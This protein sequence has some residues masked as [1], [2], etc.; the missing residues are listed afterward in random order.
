M[1]GHRYVSTGGYITAAIMVLTACSSPAA[2]A[3]HDPTDT[4]PPDVTTTAPAPAW[5]PSTT[6]GPAATPDLSEFSPA[7]RGVIEEDTGET[8]GPRAVPTWDQPS[9]TAAA[10]AATTAMTA[11]ARPSL[12]YATWWGELEPLLSADAAQDYAY[13]DPAN[14]PATQVT[15]PATLADETSAY[16]ARV[17]V[18][19]D[20]GDYVVVLSRSDG[21]AAWLVTRLTPP[22]GH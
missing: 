5:S 22:G 10:D 11:F 15:G 6:A 18:P 21:A 16:V 12:D 14:I 9:R 7:P 13:V 8:T 3:A 19:T 20:V 17:I 4:H 1:S 2:P